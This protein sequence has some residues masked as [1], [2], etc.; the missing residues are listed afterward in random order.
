MCVCVSASVCLCTCFS[1]RSALPR[2]PA[3]VC[4]SWFHRAVRNGSCQ[5]AKCPIQIM[6]L[7]SPRPPSL[8]QKIGFEVKSA[9]AAAAGLP[10]PR[11]FASA[12]LELKATAELMGSANSA[13]IS[14]TMGATTPST[15][16]AVRAWA[17]A[18]IVPGTLSALRAACVEPMVARTNGRAP[19][20]CACLMWFDVAWHH[21]VQVDI[22][23]N[24]LFDVTTLGGDGTVNTVKKSL[25]D[26]IALFLST[27]MHEARCVCR[28]VVGVGVT[29]V[30]AW[31]RGRDSAHPRRV[32][33]G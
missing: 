27:G 24:T 17:P 30:Y 19:A 14:G 12:L 1:V 28:R 31:G 11:S 13:A 16:D 10:A 5:G 22:E 23:F 33:R 6:L 26:F 8:F 4:S 3:S 9:A 21:V 25:Q 15:Q 18:P 32:W 2:V 7:P 20:C 29:L